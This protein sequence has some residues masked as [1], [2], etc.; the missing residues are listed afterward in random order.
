MTDAQRL[1]SPV[2]LATVITGM[3][4]G[5]LYSSFEVGLRRYATSLSRDADQA[6]DLVA[7]TFARAAAN[8]VLLQGLDAH[9]VQAWLYRV[10]K[11]LFIDEQRAR[12][13]QYDLLEQMTREAEIAPYT[14]DELTSPELL[15]LVSESDGELL[16]KRY[17]E[18][19][20]SREIGR[21]LG[22]P[23]ATVRS[24]IRAALQRLRRQY[25]RFLQL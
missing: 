19:M 9:Q 25:G 13:R 7:E 3:T 24:R 5:A 2:V 22:I 20:S 12:Q 6:E 16:L 15:E 21:E 4:L 10:L 23:A 17:V 14:V 11:N 1:A 8:T 18:G